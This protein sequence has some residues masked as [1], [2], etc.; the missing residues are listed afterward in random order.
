MEKEKLC[1][2][3]MRKIGANTSCPYCRNDKNDIQKE[4]YLPLKTI[5]GGRYLVG[6]LVSTN[7]EGSTYNAFDMEAKTPVTLR[8]LY[9]KGIVS[10]GEGHYCLVNVGKAAEFIEAKDSFLKLWRKL[11]TIKGYKALT[12]VHDVFE[13]LG[14]VYSVSEFLGEGQTLREYLLNKSQGYISWEE[15]RVLFMPVLS[16]IGELHKE[17]IIHGGISPTTLVVDA[18]GQMRI[19]GYCTNDVRV[20]KTVLD[21]E[22]FDG[23]AAVEQYGLSSGIGTYT[24]IY[25][26]AAVLYRTLIGSTPISA[27]SRL[28]NDKLM[29]PGKFAE[30]LPAYVINALVNALQI[31][32]E[33]RTASADDLRD[34]LSASPAAAGTAAVAYSTAYATS[35]D[36]YSN[37]Q[38]APSEEP[39]FDEVSDG[40]DFEQYDEEPKKHKKSTVVAFVVT[41]VMVLA[42]I[43]ALFFGLKGCVNK[44]D[45]DSDRK[46]KDDIETTVDSNTGNDGSGGQTTPSDPVDKEELPYS[47]PNFEG[48]VADTIIND[49]KYSD[50]LKFEVDYIDSDEDIGVV[51]SQDRREGTVIGSKVTIKLEVS[52]GRQVPDDLEGELYEDV[53]KTLNDAGFK[54]VKVEPGRKATTKSEENK[55]YSVVYAKPETDSWENIPSNGRLSASDKIIVYYYESQVP[56]EPEIP[57]TPETPDT[58]DDNTGNDTPVT[59]PVVDTPT[60][61]DNQG[62]NNSTGENTNTDTPTTGDE[63]NAD[64]SDDT[65]Q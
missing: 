37:A 43:I 28:T 30:Q 31:L 23:Y 27:A 60:G 11:A 63:G 9:P 1:L 56:E 53:V 6:K 59:P 17:G 49:P 65:V 2:R 25:A 22:I 48:E 41:V 19:T 13:D 62:D 40:N 34:E 21:C 51:V 3:C 50:V 52:Q 10:R 54:N 24:D 55:V 42:I 4:P 58:P 57:D 15:A 45:D 20:E 18:N 29:I 38:Q 47:I 33:D 39:T 26:F 12:P 35:N 44:D 61:D 14:T 16:A 36:V 5:V 8:E 64:S 46:K 7:G 32:P